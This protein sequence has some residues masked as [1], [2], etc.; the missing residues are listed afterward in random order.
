VLL[1]GVFTP[2]FSL[3]V[4][5]NVNY[6]D[7]GKGDGILILGLATISA[8]LTLARWYRGLWATGLASIALLAFT[9]T[10]FQLRIRRLQED[11][12]FRWPDSAVRGL[13]ALAADALR[14]EWGWAVLGLGAILLMATA[15]T[16]AVQRNPQRAVAIQVGGGVCI[17]GIFLL[18]SLATW[19]IHSVMRWAE[20]ETAGEV[21]SRQKTEAAAR[22][23]AARAAREE[24]ARAAKEE[25]ARLAKE[26]ADAAARKEARRTGTNQDLVPLPDRVAI[27][28]EE[29][30]A[31]WANAATQAVQQGAVRVRISSIR[32]EGKRLRIQLLVEN[33]DRARSIPFSGWRDPTAKDPP[34][35]LDNLGQPWEGIAAKAGAPPAE[36]G[37]GP[38][39]IR[40]GRS[41]VEEV[42]FAIPPRGTKVL[43][44]E[45]PAVAFGG[46]GRLR[47]QVPK[48]MLLLQAPR[49]RG[50]DAALELRPLLKDRSQRRREEAAAALGELGPDAAVAVVDLVEA[51]ADEA[52]SVR[53]AA[54]DTLGRVGPEAKGTVPALVA[55]LGDVENKVRA[56]AA[57]ALEKVAPPTKADGF[58]LGKLLN[59]RDSTVRARAR[60]ADALARIGPDARGALDGLLEALRDPSKEVRTAAGKA[61][62][63]L[64]P[65]QAEDVLALINALGGKTAEARLYALHAL[66]QLG[67]RARDAVPALAD[68]MLDSDPAFRGKAAAIL[69]KIDRDAEVQAYGK[70]LKENDA[71]LRA[72]A[73]D[74]LGAAGSRAKEAVQDLLVVASVDD[75]PLL[76]VKAG[77]AVW[78]IQGD[79]PQLPTLFGAALRDKY[80]LVRREAVAGLVDLSPRGG[81]PVARAMARA[82]EDSDR[83]IRKQA[84]T[85]LNKMG[86]G[87]EVPVSSLVEAL[88]DE[89]LSED[90]LPILV[91]I[92]ASAVPLLI[93]ALESQKVPVRLGAAVALGKIGPDAK[94]AY[95]PLS[96]VFRKDSSPE[97]RKAA[98][99]ALGLIRGR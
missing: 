29:V 66:E 83:D 37:D 26:E 19:G 88:A 70:A 85:I 18:A 60:A 95:Q 91:R 90:I 40:P 45:L 75:V 4:V 57:G 39:S 51:L 48:T 81:K 61:L 87:E 86:A 52:S 79:V 21:V 36:E 78:K 8:L 98:N 64:G 1:L 3:P 32:A 82:L 62:E 73:I 17:P 9:F 16:A 65:P 99:V 54:G 89:R 31:P 63:A 59:N 94:E 20:Q 13:D 92:G 69:R 6:F 74:A 33:T 72:E 53:A 35:L 42:V 5:G 55:A 7:N 14:M 15:I 67:P 46:T 80:V 77:R 49:L 97:V 93:D 2:I 76:R 47:L 44:L 25:A 50:T 10:T 11:V 22:E 96:A 12:D 28:G 34:R 30:P 23:E 58:R 68:A 71:K 27:P 24:A 41:V 56:A 43:R 84:A 38:Q